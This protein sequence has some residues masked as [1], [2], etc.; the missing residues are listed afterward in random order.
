MYIFLRWI[1]KVGG[2]YLGAVISRAEEKVKRHLGTAMLAKAGLSLGLLMYVQDRLYGVVEVATMLIAVELAAIA[3]YEIVGPICVR[4]ALFKAGE[5]R[6]P[7][8]EKKKKTTPASD[9]QKT[10]PQSRQNVYYF[11]QALHGF[12]IRP[13]KWGDSMRAKDIMNKD[14]ITITTT[15]S[16][17]EAAKLMADHNI[18]GLP[19]IDSSGQPV[20]MISE[21]DIIQRKSLFENL[22]HWI[23][24]GIF[25]TPQERLFR[26][27]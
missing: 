3:F 10:V 2:C 27:Q 13:K 26:E 17:R 6:M 4:Y 1:G 11:R 18:S 16:V 24:Y 15:D 8:P 25:F 21:S 5:A 12:P 7:E 9:K 22:E 20:G 19:V 23:N 14:L